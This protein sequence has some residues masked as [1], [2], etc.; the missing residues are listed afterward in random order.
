MSVSYITHKG[1]KILYI[2][3]TKCKTIPET[4]VVLDEVKTEFYNST[5][6]TKEKKYFISITL[7]V[8]PFL[9]L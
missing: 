9:K 4:L 2:D 5:G 1:K 6:V 8:K 7:N 3:Y